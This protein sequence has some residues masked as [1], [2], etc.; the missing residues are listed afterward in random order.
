[1]ENTNTAAV[2]PKDLSY[3]ER[4][5]LVENDMKELS[6]KITQISDLDEANAMNSGLSMNLLRC[7]NILY[8]SKKK[9]SAIKIAYMKDR[10]DKFIKFVDADLIAYNPEVEKIYDDINIYENVIIYVKAMLENVASKRF[11]LSRPQYEEI[12]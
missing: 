1:M 9:L 6:K 5:L 2:N 8:G 12:I 4:V 10:K 11:H 3:E 7:R